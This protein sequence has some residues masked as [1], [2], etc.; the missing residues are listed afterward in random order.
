MRPILISLVLG[1][2]A[3]VPAT[4]LLHKTKYD[5]GHV[6]TPDLS[7]LSTL[8]GDGERQFLTASVKSEQIV[9]T[10]MATGTL[11]PALNVEVG[12]VLSGQV[13]RL[14]IDFNDKVEKGQVLAELD[15]RT[16]ALAV[17]ASRAAY[18]GSQFEIESYKARLKRALLDQWQAEHQLPV[19][20]ARVDSAKIALET[21]DRDLKRK[22]WLQEREVA[23][24]ADVQNVQ[25]RRDSANSSLRE[26]Q[27]NLA[28]QTGLVSAA[29]ADVDRARAEL[30]N[31][32]A[33]ESKLKALWRSASVDLERTKIRSPID[34]IV[35]GRNV[36]QGQTLATGLEAKTLFTIA[37]NLDA[38]EIEARIDESDIA[39]IKTGQ[40]A[41]FTVDAF[42]GRVFSAKV[43]QIRMA[44]KI[45]SNVVTYTVVLTTSNPD[46]I[47]LPGMTVM[48]NIATR[49]APKSMT[50]PMAA[51]HYR[52][53]PVAVSTET[54]KSVHDNSI[55][56]LRDGKAVPISVVKGADDG[57]D[58][59]VSSTQLDPADVVIVGDK[60]EK[61]RHPSGEL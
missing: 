2:V 40:E 11:V 10:V 38:M 41:T 39:G 12:S 13:S 55:W 18:Q 6:E 51:L 54:K 60:N 59:A 34:G 61:S 22:L 56:V 37:G 3:A 36:T 28:N 29:Q 32:Q 46:G 24:I 47:L 5:A 43:K 17:D 19:F 35:V 33:T 50:V 27:A 48:A 49:K 1:S 26:A 42:P 15:D 9:K 20:Q 53:N 52:P 7:W 44:P 45:V 14:L 25:S 23:A 57:K 31:A 21:A 16:Y 58:V 30:A 8:S 4:S